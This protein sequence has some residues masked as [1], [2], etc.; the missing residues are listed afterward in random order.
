LNPAFF[1]HENETARDLHVRRFKAPLFSDARV[2]SFSLKAW[3]DRYTGRHGA[4]PSLDVLAS[5]ASPD[6][7]LEER[8][9]WLV[10]VVQWIR[11]PGHDGE[12]PAANMS[13]QSGR[14]R[15]LLDILDRNPAWKLAVARTLRSIIRETRA[16]ALFS[17]TGLPRQFGLLTEIGERLTRKF[18]PTQP[19]SAELGV[20][21]E[22]LF[23]YRDDDAWIENLDEAALERFGALLEHG[24]GPADAGWNKLGEEL[25]RLF[26]SNP[27]AVEK[28]ERARSGL[29]QIGDGALVHFRR[30]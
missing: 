5:S 29:F 2:V 13:L 21:F 14:L 6:Q 9:N 24:A 26:G 3:I 25:D 12:K 8:L 15:R 4:L 22:R 1:Q 10:D 18:L 16:V 19:G 20:L 11:R 30:A 27:G 17:E 23:P 7:P 28:S